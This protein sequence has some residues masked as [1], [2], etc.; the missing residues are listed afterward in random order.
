MDFTSALAAWRNVNL[1][2]LQSHLDSVVG[3]LTDLQTQSL[4]SRKQLADK[5]REF[6]KLSDEAKLEGYKPLLKAYQA[7]IDG[8]TRR[9]REAEG[10]IRRVDERLR[11]VA[12]PY[13]ILNVVI[14]SL[15]TYQQGGLL[16][17]M[18][19]PYRFTADITLEGPD[20]QRRRI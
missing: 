4:Q 12:D 14:V 13:A 17:L 2:G 5:T 6:K 16:L 20:H 19:N 15:K 11:G 18:A 3:P 9:A 7:E 1:P 8:L 10:S